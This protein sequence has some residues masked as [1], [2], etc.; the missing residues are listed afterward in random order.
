MPFRAWLSRLWP[1]PCG[2]ARKWRSSRAAPLLAKRGLKR[3]P[4]G[5]GRLQRFRCSKGAGHRPLAVLWADLDALGDDEL[6]VGHADEA[7]DGAQVGLHM[8]RRRPVGRE[9]AARD[10]DDPP[11]AAGQ[12]FGAL[13]AIAE[14]LARRQDAVDPGLELAGN[15]E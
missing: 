3:Q 15:R 14:G 13:W 4:G 11:L 10:G 7:E 6:D 5:S 9:V 1:Q 12:A 8:L 2:G